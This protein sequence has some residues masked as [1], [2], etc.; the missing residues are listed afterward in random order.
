MR[1]RSPSRALRRL[2]SPIKR[3]SLLTNTVVASGR[4]RIALVVHWQ[5][6]CVHGNKHRDVLL[7]HPNPMRQALRMR[8][9]LASEQVYTYYMPE[10]TESGRGTEHHHVLLAVSEYDGWLPLKFQRR[11][12]QRRHG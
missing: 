10:T 5:H 6:H 1:S 12:I 8:R 3:N 11:L 7:L 9:R 4:T 2:Q